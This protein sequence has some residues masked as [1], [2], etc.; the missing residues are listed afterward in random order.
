MLVSDR[1]SRIAR[2]LQTNQ[3]SCYGDKMPC[4]LSP[5]RQAP[6]PHRCVLREGPPEGVPSFGGCG[7]QRGYTGLM[8]HKQATQRCVKLR[9]CGV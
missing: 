2:A 7:L 8:P 9:R 1:A 5:E 4:N 3:I 6:R